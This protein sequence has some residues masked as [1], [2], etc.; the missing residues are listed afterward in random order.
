MFVEVGQ[1]WLINDTK[2]S[3][4]GVYIDG[5]DPESGRL[6][7]FKLCSV[8][9]LMEEQSLKVQSNRFTGIEVDQQMRQK[10]NPAL[11]RLTELN[12]IKAQYMFVRENKTTPMSKNE[13]VSGYTE[14][15]YE[16]NNISW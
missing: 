14:S 6:S 12:N 4:D 8:D 15:I 16:R 9:R 3:F 2:A 13:V 1:V 10:E 5:I 11:I 7:I